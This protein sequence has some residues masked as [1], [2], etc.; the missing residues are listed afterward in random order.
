[1]MPA[2]YLQKVKKIVIYIYRERE[3]DKANTAKC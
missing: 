2:T 3:N 1:M